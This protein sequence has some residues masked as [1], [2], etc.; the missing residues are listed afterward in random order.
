MDKISLDRINEAHPKIREI[1]KTS[2]IKANNSL[3]KGCRLRLAYVYRSPEE[4]EKLYKLI[5]ERTVSSQ[6]SDAK[7][8]KTKIKY[9]EENIEQ[10]KQYEELSII[11]KI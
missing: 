8:L 7:L 11:R 2:Y 6:M 4:Q 10:I 1:L 9:Y 5:W 3:G